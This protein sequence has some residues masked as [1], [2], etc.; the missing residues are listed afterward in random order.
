M[1]II[2]IT[3]ARS[4]STRLPN[5]VLKEIEGK[6]LLQLHIERISSSSLINQL[7]VATTI[8]EN[9]EQIVRMMD[10]IGVQSFRGSEADVLD[11]FYQ[12]VKDL[13]PDY[14]VRLTSDCPLIDADLIDEVI[15]F[16]I[17]SDLDYVSNTLE[18]TYPDGQDIEVFR[19]STLKQAWKEAHL[20]SDREHVTPYIWRNSSYKKGTLFSSGNFKGE[21]D[22]SSIRMTVD[23]PADFEL[24]KHLIET[25]GTEK[26]WQEYAQYILDSPDVFN[27]NGTIER[28]EGYIKSINED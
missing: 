25:L 27:M 24:I 17:K 11:R 23:E 16:A 20:V 13:N 19:F 28:N 10:K 9:D 18:P 4:G 12:C 3:Q 5:K 15:N 1:K 14:V 22:F 21:K 7:I 2:A 6:S 26:P 8:A